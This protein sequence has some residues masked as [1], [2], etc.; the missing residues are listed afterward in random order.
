MT[1]NIN[2]AAELYELIRRGEIDQ[3]EALRVAR[4]FRRPIPVS[5]P[6]TPTGTPASPAAPPSTW[7]RC[8][9]GSVT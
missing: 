5:T 2:S 4:R 8:A 6:D 7:R 3:D 9:S 1:R